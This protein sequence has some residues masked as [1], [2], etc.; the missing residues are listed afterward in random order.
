MVALSRM[1]SLTPARLM[2]WKDCG[3][4]ALGKRAD[5]I[6]MDENLQVKK[7]ITNKEN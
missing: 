5:L 2:G 7:V 6:I 3:E 1:A 4:I